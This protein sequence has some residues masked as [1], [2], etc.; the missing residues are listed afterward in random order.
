[1][2]IEQYGIFWS[3]QSDPLKREFFMI[4]NGGRFERNGRT[5]GNG[6]FFHYREAQ[7]LLWP[8]DYHNRWTDLILSQ[9]LNNRITVITGPKDC[10]KTRTISKYALVDY[11]AF[12]DNTLMLVSS[13]T[14][15]AIETRVWGTIKMLFRQGRIKHPWL[16]GNV[17][18]SKKAISTDDL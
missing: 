12:P 10:G 6:L 17:L 9:I 11:W 7:K 2:P 5:V 14:L 8:D 1:M 4:Q 18:D 16:A 13:T 3:E 15:V